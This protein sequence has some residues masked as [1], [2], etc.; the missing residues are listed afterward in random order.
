MFTTQSQLAAQIRNR[1]KD[2]AWKERLAKGEVI[3]PLTLYTEEDEASY[4][5]WLE[6]VGETGQQGA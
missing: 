6:Y 4:R 1:A 2:A 3:D 5:K